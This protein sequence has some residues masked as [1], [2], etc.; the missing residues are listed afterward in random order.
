LQST[1]VVIIG[2]GPYGLSLAAHLSARG[3]GY[4]IFG[5]T[6][7]SWRTQM[8]RGMQL[9]SEGFASCLDD[10][11]DSY[12]L[13]TFCQERG[14]PYRDIGSPVPIETF[15][16]Y[17]LAFQ[18]RFVP[19]L[20]R[21]QVTRLAS[22]RSGFTL[23]LDDGEI[24]TARQVVV[25]VGVGHFP[26][27]PPELAE[28]SDAHLSHSS[29]HAELDRFRGK[30]V[31][32][33]GAGASAVDLAALLHEAGS[34]V[35]LVARRRSIE[36]HAPPE[37][38]PRR[39]SERLRNPRSGLGLGWRSRLCE[40][41]P[42]VFRMMP[43]DFRLRVVSRHLGPAPGWFVRERVEQH[44]PMLL[45][46]RL[47]TGDSRGDMAQ[48]RIANDNGHEQVLEA[49]HLIAATGYRVDLRRL[50]F[51][52]PATL[53]RI[54]MADH[55]PVLSTRFETSLPGLYFVGPAAANCFG[56]LMRFACGNRFVARRLAPYIAAR[57]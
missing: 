41:A 24:V 50:S 39:L 18:Q 26:H 31:I 36:F 6:M 57:A 27:L 19:S 37:R 46:T 54:R 55:T 34:S 29:H 5:E 12:K 53:G 25:A 51:L 43:Q 3:I 20:E 8:P 38:R 30:D 7:H 21:K 9:K 13:A 1:S 40:D 17:G 28:M 33:I 16:D 47:V 4:R 23:R 49:D 42:L 15:I 52:A 35:R 56:P 44:V 10:P 22:S 2:A 11:D 32:V 45:G 14:L 48:L